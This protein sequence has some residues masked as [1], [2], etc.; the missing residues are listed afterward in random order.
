M[1]HDIVSQIDFRRRNSSKYAVRQQLRV[2]SLGRFR[3]RRGSNVTQLT[4]AIRRRRRPRRSLL[5][6]V[7]DRQSPHSVDF[8]RRRRRSVGKRPSRLWRVSRM[9][10]AGRLQRVPDLGDYWRFQHLRIPA[11]RQTVSISI[12][13][14]FV[15][16]EVIWSVNWQVNRATRHTTCSNSCPL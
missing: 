6:Q 10:V 13:I 11:L 4:L 1:R 3:R 8:G 15:Q 14:Y 2:V 5:E 7:L 16:N 12:S 9:P